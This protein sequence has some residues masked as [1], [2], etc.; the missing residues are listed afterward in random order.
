MMPKLLI[1]KHKDSCCTTQEKAEEHENVVQHCWQSRLPWNKHHCLCNLM[2]HWKTSSAPLLILNQ[3]FPFKSTGHFQGSQGRYKPQTFMSGYLLQKFLSTSTWN[4]S[5]WNWSSEVERDNKCAGILRGR[6]S[7]LFLHYTERTASKE[8]TRTG[9]EEIGDIASQ[10][11]PIICSTNEPLLT[12]CP[13]IVNDMMVLADRSIFSNLL[14]TS[15]FNSARLFKKGF[16]L[17]RINSAE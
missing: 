3:T 6:K 10:E 2:R 15:Y 1:Y 8:S 13:M 5:S 4:C 14:C 12:V 16:C 11:D 7:L 9:D 17:W